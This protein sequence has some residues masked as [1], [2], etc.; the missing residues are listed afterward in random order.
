MKYLI[1]VFTLLIHLITLAQE[2]SEETFP[3][4]EDAVFVMTENPP[5]FPGCGELEEVSEQASCTQMGIVNFVMSKVIYPEKAKMT[6]IK[7]KV[8]VSFVI[9]K[10]GEVEGIE[11]ISGV[12]P[13]L[14][15]AS[16]E[17]IEKLPLMIPAYQKGKKVNF[18]YTIPVNFTFKKN[19]TKRKK[20]NMEKRN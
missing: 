13:L 15:N 9:N 5:V 7:G 19:K 17:A 3:I 18:K 6:G 12:H 20:K 14:D 16:I 4:A 1:L 10:E 11:I 8:F 2:E